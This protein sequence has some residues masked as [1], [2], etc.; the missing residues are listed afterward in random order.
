MWC[1]LELD[2]PVFCAPSSLFIASRLD[3]D[4]HAHTCRLAFHGRA[5]HLSAAVDVLPR[6]R[7]AKTRVREGCVERVLDDGT[8]VVRDLLPAGAPIDRYFGMA[9]A[10]GTGEAGT[11]EGGFGTTGKLRVRCFGL[12][13]DTLAR[14]P[15][16]KSKKGK[17][18][19]DE[20]PPL[21][22]VAVLFTF[23][24]FVHDPAR[25]MHQ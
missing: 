18:D 22:P 7:V 19:A 16:A 23:K 9:V 6:L 11:I 8:L 2:V 15:S 13:P 12:R 21:D 24:R 5:A 1:I 20:P 3:T 14:L 17:K 10:L 25:K 4:A